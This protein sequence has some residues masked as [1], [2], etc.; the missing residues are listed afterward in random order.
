MLNKFKAQRRPK[1]MLS[2]PEQQSEQQKRQT[3]LPPHAAA[4]GCFGEACVTV[5]SSI[6][7]MTMAVHTPTHTPTCERE[8]IEA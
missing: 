4:T 2:F 5:K 6:C 8:P 7:G 3:Q 1:V